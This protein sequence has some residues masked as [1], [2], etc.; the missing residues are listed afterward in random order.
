[1]T[2]ASQKTQDWLAE[3]K[4]GCKSAAECLAFN[5]AQIFPLLKSVGITVVMVGYSGCGDSGQIDDRLVIVRELQSG[6]APKILE[7]KVTLRVPSFHGGNATEQTL[8]LREAFE[9]LC[10]MLLVTEHAGWEM[11]EGGEGTFTF[12]A[13]SELIELEHTQFHTESDSYSYSHE[14]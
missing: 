14:W 11:N 7:A 6:P 1:M 9:H 3:Y 10:W 4:E 12:D 2:D 8:S 5:K 13:R